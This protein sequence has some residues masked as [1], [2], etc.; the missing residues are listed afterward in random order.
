MS[1]CSWTISKSEAE[2]ARP[3]VVRTI[4]AALQILSLLNACSSVR[5]VRVAGAG[6]SSR[7]PGYLW[8]LSLMLTRAIY[9]EFLGS[10]VGRTSPVDLAARREPRLPLTRSFSHSRR[11]H[12]VADQDTL[13]Y[14]ARRPI[15]SELCGGRCAK[16]HGSVRILHSGTIDFCQPMTI[17]NRVR[18]DDSARQT[19]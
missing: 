19:K 6:V 7:S 8:S 12:G 13:D 4:Q 16:T 9:H 15:G 2:F 1:R 5:A 14:V 17:P 10:R 3:S 11:T 18:P